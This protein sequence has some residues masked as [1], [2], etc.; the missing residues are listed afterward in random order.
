MSY[1]CADKEFDLPKENKKMV[2]D[3]ISLIMIGSIAVVFVTSSL[4]IVL[5]KKWCSLRKSIGCDREIKTT[6]TK[7]NGDA[8]EEQYLISYQF[9]DEKPDILNRGKN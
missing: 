6:L 3:I 7:I 5:V 8:N 1:L 4:I 2:K 9:N